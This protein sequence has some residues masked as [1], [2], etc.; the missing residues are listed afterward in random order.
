MGVPVHTGSKFVLPPP[1]C[2]VLRGLGDV[3]SRG[4]GQSSSLSLLSQILTSSGS[5]LTDTPRTHVLP[6]LWASLSPIKSTHTINR[7]RE[8][9]LCL[10]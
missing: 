8:L 6:A 1:F 7:D 3:C 10:I 2:S 4:G 5:T 9:I